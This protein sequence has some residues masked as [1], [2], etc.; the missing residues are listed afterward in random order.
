MKLQIQIVVLLTALV[1]GCVTTNMGKGRILASSEDV[2]RINRDLGISYLRQGNFE[3]ARIKLERSIQEENNS[4]LAHRALG[5]V[6]D[7][8]GDPVAAEKEYRTAVRQGP[9]DPDALNELAIFLCRSGEIKAAMKYYDRALV[10]PLNATRYAIYANAGTCVKNIDLPRA[11]NYL[12]KALAEKPDFPDALY[13]MGDVAYRRENY[14]QARAF[15]ERRLGAAPATPDILWLAYK[16]EQ[17]LGD[18]QAANNYGGIILNSFPE[19]PEARLLV[20]K[21]RDAG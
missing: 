4:P 6:Y 7:Q 9:D 17:A 1:T 3:E 21:Q 8:L 20:E 13:Q 16:V 5:L 2:A 18:Y 11:E 14:L 10:I 12:R 15:V 19:S